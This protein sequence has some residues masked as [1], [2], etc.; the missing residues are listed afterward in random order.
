MTFIQIGS[1]IGKTPN[2]QLFHIINK[3]YNCIFI[4]P[5]PYLFNILVNNY[6]EA[7]PNNNFI[8]I[9]KAVSD[10]IGYIDLYIPS[11]KNNFNNYPFWAS[12]LS[13][14]NPIH[15][16][17][18]IPDLIVD[19]INVE[20]TTINKIIEDYN[21]TNI[22]FLHLDTEGHDYQILKNYNFSIKPKQIMFEHKHMDGVF[23][24]GE[25]YNEL[26]NLLYNYSYKIVQQND[27]DT[28]LNL[29]E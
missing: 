11:E 21:I 3:D 19:K 4:E 12:Q 25:K 17:R 15:I 29:I 7:Y 28:L 23:K 13:S 14:V 27:E 6:N 22:E 16:Q 9:N 8:F 2:D 24:T 10:Y 1:H 20:T 26:I 5:V 18:H